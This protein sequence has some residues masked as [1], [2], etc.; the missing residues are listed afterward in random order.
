MNTCFFYVLGR[1]SAPSLLV[2]LDE[3]RVES[4]LDVLGVKEFREVLIDTF[5][6]ALEQT[7]PYICES[8]KHCFDQINLRYGFVSVMNR[9]R[10]TFALI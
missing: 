7:L 2:L 9:T 4:L 1:F 10:F 6:I 5:E 3:Y 8:H